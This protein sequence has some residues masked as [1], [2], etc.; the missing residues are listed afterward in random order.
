M[1]ETVYQVRCDKEGCNEIHF[2]N[3]NSKEKARQEAELDGWLWT[4]EGVICTNCRIDEI[5][6]EEE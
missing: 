1:V 6:A 3:A 5:Y 4:Q 2:V